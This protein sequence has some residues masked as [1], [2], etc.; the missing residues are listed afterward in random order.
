VL[1]GQSLGA[2]GEGFFRVALTTTEERL[3]EAAGRIA[4]LV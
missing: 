1:P 2:G 4:N 3:R